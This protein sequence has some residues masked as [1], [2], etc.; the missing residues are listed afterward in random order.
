MRR[1]KI[2]RLTVGISGATVFLIS[3]LAL[4]EKLFEVP[5]MGFFTHW[6]GSAV[7]ALPTTVSFLVVGSALVLL[8]KPED[9]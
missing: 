4:F 3:A 6:G 9:V 1:A 5:F 7:M 2:I 8:G